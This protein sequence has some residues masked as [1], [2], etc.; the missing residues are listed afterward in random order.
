MDS[1]RWTAEV[2]AQRFGLRTEA[3]RRLLF[4]LAA[5]RLVETGGGSGGTGNM[6]IFAVRDSAAAPPGSKVS[7]QGQ[8]L[9]QHLQDIEDSQQRA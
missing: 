7:V 9:A 4:S 6:E 1:K 2:L 5:S 3:V 8:H